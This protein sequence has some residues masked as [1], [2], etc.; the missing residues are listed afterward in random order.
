MTAVEP[1]AQS[2]VATLTAKLGMSVDLGEQQLAEAR[3]MRAAMDAMTVMQPVTFRAVG[4][5]LADAAGFAVIQFSPAGPDQG[6]VWEIQNLVVGGD[7]FS[8][9]AAGTPEFYASAMDLRSLG[10]TSPPLTDVVDA[11][12]VTLPTLGFY[13]RGQ[14][15]LRP[16]ERLYVRIVG[17]TEGQQ[18]AAV[19]RGIDY[20]EGANKQVTSL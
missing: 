13:S 5:A 4:S 20:Q 18:Y 1:E 11:T 6:H 19:A 12:T 8:T 17:G 14:F 15:T 9:A 16:G 3:K 7:T 2:L 10:N